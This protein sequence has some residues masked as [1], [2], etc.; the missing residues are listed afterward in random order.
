[1]PLSLGMG[2]PAAVEVRFGRGGID[3]GAVTASAGP[4]P[5]P[6]EV[7]AANNSMSEAFGDAWV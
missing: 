6:G 4:N 7:T 2:E 1:M 5:A 3:G